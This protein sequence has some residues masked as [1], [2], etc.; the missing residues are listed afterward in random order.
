[1]GIDSMASIAIRNELSQH[2]GVLLDAELLR[3]NVSIERIASE[4]FHATMDRPDAPTSSPVQISGSSM[5]EIDEWHSFP[6]ASFHA[7]FSMASEEAAKSS[8]P[9]MFVLSTPASGSSLVLSKLQ[10]LEADFFVVEDANLLPFETMGQR[11]RY[12]QLKAA[13]MHNK[14]SDNRDVLVDIVAALT[15]QTHESATLTVSKWSGRFATDAHNDGSLSTQEVYSQLRK[16]CAPRILCDVS[17]T[18]SLQAGFL[19]RALHIFRNPIFLHLTRHPGVSIPSWKCDIKRQSS[20]RGADLSGEI[21]RLW[22]ERNA[23]IATFLRDHCVD[24]MDEA[25]SE[26]HDEE[27]DEPCFMHVRY[28]DLDTKAEGAS[29]SVSLEELCLHVA[30]STRAHGNSGAISVQ[31]FS[32]PRFEPIILN[33]CGVQPPKVGPLVQMIGRQ[34]GYEFHPELPPGCIRLNNKQIF[35]NGNRQRMQ[36]GSKAGECRAEVEHDQSP[37]VLF[38][39]ITGQIHHLTSIAALLPI[40]CVGLQYQGGNEAQSDLRVLGQKY[41]LV[42]LKLLRIYT[43]GKSNRGSLQKGVGNA[44]HGKQVVRLGGYSYGCRIAYAAAE[45]LESQMTKGGTPQYEV[46][47]LL[48]DGSIDGSVPSAGHRAVERFAVDLYIQANGLGHLLM[49]DTSEETGRLPEGARDHLL[50]ALEAIEHSTDAQH[51]A[52]DGSRSIVSALLPHAKLLRDHVAVV[53]RLVSLAEGFET[54]HRLQGRALRI[55]SERSVALEDDDGCGEVNKGG[56]ATEVWPP[57]LSKT[58]TLI[59]NLEIFHAR[60]GH[61]SFFKVDALRVAHAISNWLIGS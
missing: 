27:L 52:D 54:T 48:L 35:A 13:S 42:I 26:Y 12:L 47:L 29:P 20:V 21:G 2:F 33:D 1:M 16:F 56:V 17:A 57:D 9:I 51:V 43:Q 38:H 19:R 10:H 61:F 55:V 39:D 60:G 45:W 7:P 49:G 44:M 3:S 25:S 46:E 59:E 8:M 40:P 11:A 18:T 5:D 15:S 23:S 6:C 36:D 14:T 4:L 34:F 30:H 37:L 53:A 41:A 28:E 31:T 24:V 32:A 50:Q 58:E 22:A